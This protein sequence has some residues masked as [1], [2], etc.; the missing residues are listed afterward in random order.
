MSELGFEPAT[1]QPQAQ[2]INHSVTRPPPNSIYIQPV[3]VL[4]LGALED[5]LQLHHHVLRPLIRNHSVTRPPFRHTAGQ[6][7]I[8]WSSGRVDL[9][10]LHH[11]VLRP[12]VGGVGPGEE[13]ITRGMSVTTQVTFTSQYNLYTHSRSASLLLGALE[14]TTFSFSYTTT[15]S[16]FWYETTRPHPNHIHTGCQCLIAWSSGR[17]DLCLELRKRRPLLGAPEEPTCSYNYTTTSQFSE[18]GR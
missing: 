5:L 16:A 1:S 2:C 12:L 18:F 7:R 8:A 9:F 4:L 6:C 15:F 13:G 11:H 17:D 14:E 10:Q 3:G